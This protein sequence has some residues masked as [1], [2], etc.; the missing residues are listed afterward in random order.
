MASIMRRM[1]TLIILPH[2]CLSTNDC[3]LD[4]KFLCCCFCSCFCSQ[5]A[6]LAIL[7]CFHGIVAV[8]FKS[9]YNLFVSDT[10]HTILSPAVAI[11]LIFKAVLSY[12]HYT[13]AKQ[14]LPEFS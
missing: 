13:L 12:Q 2:A 4:I 6:P 7:A 8:Y 1:I 3:L 9:N 5:V 14:V 11:L 10:T